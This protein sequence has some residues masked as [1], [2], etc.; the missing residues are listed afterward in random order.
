M[1]GRTSD[2]DVV[3]YVP[4]TCLGV[5]VCV[6][7]RSGRIQERGHTLAHMRLHRSEDT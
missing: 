5:C 7:T 4:T 6:Q 3:Q 1:F 2:L